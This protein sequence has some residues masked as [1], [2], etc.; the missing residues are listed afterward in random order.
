[1]IILQKIFVLKIMF[2]S[3]SEMPK[4]EY[5][6]EENCKEM[7]RIKLFPIKFQAITVYKY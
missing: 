6:F 7:Y 1:M 4:I 5:L 3:P 2:V